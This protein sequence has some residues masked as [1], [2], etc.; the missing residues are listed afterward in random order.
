MH[1]LAKHR[2]SLA[3]SA[4]AGLTALFTVATA[5]AASAQSVIGSSSLAPVAAFKANT[6]LL[7]IYDPNTGN[8]N[9]G[10][11]IRS[12]TSPAIAV[13]P[14]GT[15][16]VAFQDNSLH[17]LFIYTPTNAGHRDTGL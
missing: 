1:L 13:S 9:T 4:I 11:G 16:E 3:L 17:H 12:N 14:N 7:W 10:L 8:T 15:Y 6:S 2:R 5:G